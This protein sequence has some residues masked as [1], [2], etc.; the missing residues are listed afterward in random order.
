MAKKIHYPGNYYDCAGFE[1][2]LNNLAAEGLLLKGFT[3][4]GKTH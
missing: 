4:F 1:R 2:W 3:L